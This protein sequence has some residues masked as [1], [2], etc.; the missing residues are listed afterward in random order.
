MPATT[1]EAVMQMRRGLE[2]DL[3]ISQLRIGEWALSTDRKW[4]RICYAEGK[5]IKIAS[6]EAMDETLAEIQEIEDA[7]L[8]MKNAAAASATSASGSATAADESAEDAEAWAVGKR[9]GV[10]VPSTDPAYNNNSKYW[11]QHAVQSLGN[12]TDTDISNPSNND[13]LKYNSTSGKWENGV[14]GGSGSGGHTIE[15]A[16]GTDFTQRDTLQFKGTLKV[17]DDSTN[18]KTVVSDEAEEVEWSVWD[19]MTEAQRDAYS[20]GKK[21]DIL[22]APWASGRIP[23]E[24]IK[25][26]WTNPSPT[27]E[28]AAQ[29][30]TLASSD[31]DFLLVETKYKANDTQIVNSVIIPKGYRA[32]MDFGD[33][34]AGVS[35]N[36][37]RALVSTSDTS[38]SFTDA[39]IESTVNNSYLIPIAI[40]GIKSSVTVDVSGIVADVSTDA[41]K[42]VYDNTNSEL[43][44]TDVQD[45]IDELDGKVEELG[46]GARYGTAVDLTSYT[47]SD[48]YT[49]PAD[50]HICANCYG[51]NYGII[52]I[53]GGTIVG[54]QQNSTQ[55]CFTTFVKKGM[56]LYTQGITGTPSLKYYPFA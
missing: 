54:V 30:I 1:I 6:Q 46:K 11:A 2:N 28:F 20:A 4:V 18:E 34:V 31:Y 17:S 16:S 12:L 52:V 38:Y 53:N 40:Y 24:L 41:S 39:Y 15:D 25:T 19:A 49:I 43:Q 35:K 7:I 45:A 32:L 8:V 23:V 9:G 21:L 37:Y 10:D 47:A 51:N 27:T 56:K 26:L 22:H 13:V 14:G 50:G 5:V 29:N 55:T 44:A 42:C 36:M 3:D 33:I 48:Q